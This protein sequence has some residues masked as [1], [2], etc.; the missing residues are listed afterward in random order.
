METH[1]T[2]RMWRELSIIR[3]ANTPWARQYCRR[4]I[5]LGPYSTVGKPN[6][7]IEYPFIDETTVRPSI[8]AR[9]RV[10]RWQEVD[11]QGRTL[12]LTRLFGNRT[13][14]AAYAAVY[15]RSQ[16]EQNAQLR[17]GTDDGC[18]VWHNGALILSAPVER[19]AAPDQN[20][21]DVKL[22]EGLNL[23]LIKVVNRYGPGW[24]LILRLTDQNGN[25]LSNIEYLTA[26]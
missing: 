7:G 18:R 23:F 14:C 12:D 10:L 24:E 22:N 16:Q 17:I 21:V 4:F 1:A 8:G 25:P 11:I 19:S 20:I 3:P 15:V 9:V 5:V 26:P 13:D 2:R 6:L